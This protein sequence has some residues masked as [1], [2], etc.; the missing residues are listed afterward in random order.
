MLKNGG[1]WKDGKGLNTIRTNQKHIKT[2]KIHELLSKGHLK[3]KFNFKVIS[4]LRH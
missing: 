3:P 4:Q 1:L 2:H